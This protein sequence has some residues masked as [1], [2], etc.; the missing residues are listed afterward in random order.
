MEDNNLDRVA[1]I[2]G[3]VMGQEEGGGDR[4]RGADEGAVI[5]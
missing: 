5:D 4:K 3:A 1:E 2:I